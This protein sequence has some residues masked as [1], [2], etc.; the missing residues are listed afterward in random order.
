MC[1]ATAGFGGLE[2]LLDLWQWLLAAAG[3]REISWNCAGLTFGSDAHT[4]RHSLYPTDLPSPLPAP[5][6]PVQPGQL[7]IDREPRPSNFVAS[8]I[9]A[10]Y[11]E[12]RRANWLLIAASQLR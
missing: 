7:R 4:F 8:L 5:D 12:Q 9:T 6:H 10:S 11:F 1:F 2:S 3:C